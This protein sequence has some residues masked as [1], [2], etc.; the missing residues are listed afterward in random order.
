M[1]MMKQIPEAL[2]SAHFWFSGRACIFFKS[3][4]FSKKSRIE[5]I[6]YFLRSQRKNK[7]G[8]SALARGT[9]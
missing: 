8:M 1:N 6:Y 7:A 3:S 9:W 4:I 2:Q 5:F